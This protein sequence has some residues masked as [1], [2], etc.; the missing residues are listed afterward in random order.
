MNR[1]VRED[2]MITK[3]NEEQKE[4]VN[5]R[6]GFLKLKWKKG[7]FLLNTKKEQRKPVF[8]LRQLLTGIQFDSGVVGKALKGPICTY[9]FSGGV[10]MWHSDV[11]GLV[12]TTMAHEMGHNFG[13]EH[14]TDNCKCPEEVLRTITCAY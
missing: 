10:S 9:E 6:V 5:A 8:L 7:F 11:I 14:D 12:A 4:R 1:K 3:V 13:M 2:I